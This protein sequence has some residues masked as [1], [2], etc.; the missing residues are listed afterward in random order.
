MKTIKCELSKIVRWY[1]GINENVELNKEV[2]KDCV[3]SCDF[4][5]ELFIDDNKQIIEVYLDEEESIDFIL[6]NINKKFI[7]KSAKDDSTFT[8]YRVEFYKY[9]FYSEV[10]L[11]ELD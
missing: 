1:F 11:L 4:L 6:N 3:V 2:I 10:E 9:I 5:L 7:F 8:Y